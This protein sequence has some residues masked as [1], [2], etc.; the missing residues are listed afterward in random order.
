MT[1]KIIRNSNPYWIDEKHDFITSFLKHPR[2]IHAELSTNNDEYDVVVIG[3]G[4][5]G[6]SCVYWLRKLYPI[7]RFP[8]ILLLEKNFRPCSGASGRNGGFICPSYDYLADYVEDFGYENGCQWVEFQH[9]NI[10]S[11]AQVVKEN[12]IDCELNLTRGNVAL[13]RTQKELENIVKSY[14]FVKD[15]LEKHSKTKMSLDNLELWDHEK[16]QEMLHSDKFIGGLFMRESGT[17]WLAKFVFGLLKYCLEQP[18]IDLITNGKVIRIENSKN[19]ILENGRVIIAHHNIVH[20]TNA[21]SV[22]Y[23]DFVRDK[24]IP[25]RG[26]CSR[27]KSIETIFWPFGLSANEGGEYYHQSPI[28]GRITFGGCR[29]RSP[30]TEHNNQNDSEINDLIR[31]E[32]KNFFSLW[33]PDIA[34]QNCT[35][36]IEQEWT[37]IMAFTIDDLP[38]IGPLPGDNKQ[39]LLCGYNGDGVPNAF[40]CAKAVARMI[41]NDDPYKEGKENNT[42]TFLKMFLPERFTN[43]TIIQ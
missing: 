28:D 27:S 39:F 18:G 36:E 17:V 2:I 22:E 41:A 33:H 20:A 24:I 42:I 5:S 14:E 29:W 15:Y 21:Y 7:E 23:L 11:I 16:C 13:A 40:L 4:L 30:N 31:E 35:F 25:T 34:T 38:L 12:N 32:H 1:Q 19:I 26:Q 37:G 8:R 3:S 43:S 6:V 9:E 10:R